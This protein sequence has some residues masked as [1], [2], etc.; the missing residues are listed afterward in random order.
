MATLLIAVILVG[1]LLLLLR[2]R[3]AR[4]NAEL[5]KEQIFMQSFGAAPVQ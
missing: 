3:R 2:R 4:N 5:Q 1:L